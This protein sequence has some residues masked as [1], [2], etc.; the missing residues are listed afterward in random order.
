MPVSYQAF[1]SKRSTWEPHISRDNKAGNALRSIFGTSD[2][3]TL[4]RNDLRILA[5]KADL[6]QFVMATIIWGYPRS[7]RGNHVA[8]LIGHLDSL[9]RL[10][11]TARAQRIAEWN[12]HFANVLPIAGIGLSTYTKFLN[13]LSVQVQGRTALIL[14]GR[15]IRIAK[16]G[17]FEELAPLQKMSNYNANR[18]YPQYLEC[19][20]DLADSL[21]VSGEGIEFFLFEFGLYLKPPPAQQIVPADAAGGSVHAKRALPR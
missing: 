12:T 5:A 17:I 3:V 19:V 21:R 6:S 1:A 4:S 20:H 14:D 13:F 8:N 15:I 9:T 18:F 2:E 11:S 10:L 7:M 16:Q